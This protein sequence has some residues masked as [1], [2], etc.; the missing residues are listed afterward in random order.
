M[1]ILCGCGLSYHG[2]HSILKDAPGIA[3]IL[4]T[5]QLESVLVNLQLSCTKGPQN[6]AGRQ[7]VRQV[8]GRS[9]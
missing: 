1:L 4:Q 9:E 8:Q 2:N 3:D 7:K 6:E 5:H